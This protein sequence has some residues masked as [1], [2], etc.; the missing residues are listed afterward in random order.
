M[1]SLGRKIKLN[2]E[3]KHP[4]QDRYLLMTGGEQHLSLET[5]LIVL[6][7]KPGINSGANRMHTFQ[8]SRVLWDCPAL[9]PKTPC[10]S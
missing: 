6:Q 5:L 4:F 1:I 2:E 9:P 8:Q 3:Y 10:P 7:R